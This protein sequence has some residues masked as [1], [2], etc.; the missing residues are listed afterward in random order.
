MERAPRKTQTFAASLLILAL[1]LPGSAPIYPDL[2]REAL[3]VQAAPQAAGL[4][5]LD[6]ALRSRPAAAGAEERADEKAVREVLAL[7]RSDQERDHEAAV[8]RLKEWLLQPILDG[9]VPSLSEFESVSKYSEVVLSFRG[10][11]DR[12]SAV[13]PKIRQGYRNLALLQRLAK[14]NSLR[15]IA[16]SPYNQILV[17]WAGVSQAHQ[18]MVAKFS[19]LAPSFLKAFENQL[20]REEETGLDRGEQRAELKVVREQLRTALSGAVETMTEFTELIGFLTEADPADQKSAAGAEETTQLLEA[21]EFVGDYQYWLT[22]LPVARREKVENWLRQ[23]GIQVRTIPLPDRIPVYV[24]G[25][26]LFRKV[27]GRLQQP[28]GIWFDLTPLPLKSG[29][30][31]KWQ[32]IGLILNDLG[33]GAYRGENPYRLP[34][35]NMYLIDVW[36]PAKLDPALLLAE[37]FASIPVRSQWVGAELTVDSEGRPQ[38]LIFSREA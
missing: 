2:H 28:E 13:L 5:Q 11:A 7:I 4:E 36:D 8:N 30:G 20:G 34:V 23:D 27:Q 26:E 29:R 3:R 38:L 33:M 37:I 25:G 32:R 21:E 6:D 14:E 9:A 35:H 18:E 17:S 1:G 24:S 16:L 10:F 31:E 22:A 19:K 15:L 12:T